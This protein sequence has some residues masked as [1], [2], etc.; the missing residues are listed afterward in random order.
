MKFLRR[1][2]HCKLHYILFTF[3]NLFS[4]LWKNE[5][6][7][8]RSP[9]CQCICVSPSIIKFWMPEPIFLKIGMY[10][11][12]APEPISI[13]YF[14]NPSS[15]SLCLYVYPYR[16]YATAKWKHY[17]GNRYTRKSIS[18]VSKESR[19]LVL[20]RTSCLY[21]I[22]RRCQEKQQYGVEQQMMIMNLK[23]RGTLRSLSSKRTI[24]AF[25]W[26]DW[27]RA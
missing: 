5:S 4:L 6:R 9:C 16:C 25:A 23:R 21:S 22:W 1:A 19:R 2:L 7:L 27:E 18:V 24:Q 11:V 17:R 13:A 26:R 15:Q 20:P 10:D 14:I 8:M 3:I 12:I